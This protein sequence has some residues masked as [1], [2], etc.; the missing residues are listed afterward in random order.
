MRLAGFGTRPK[1]WDDYAKLGVAGTTE[2]LLHPER[3]PD[4]LKDVLDAI[5][6]DYVDFDNRDS[7]RNWWL[8]RMVHTR[9]PLEENRCSESA[10]GAVC[11]QPTSAS[12]ICRIAGLSNYRS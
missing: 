12:A 8:Y 5:G 1:E 9:R 11:R 3:V 10:R 2:V 7:T 4:H 6:G